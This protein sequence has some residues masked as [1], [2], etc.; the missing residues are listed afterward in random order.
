MSL[1]KN[2]I[3]FLEIG[4]VRTWE[5]MKKN[6]NINYLKLVFV[7]DKQLIFRIQRERVRKKLRS[8]FQSRQAMA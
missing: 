7:D 3:L 2:D 8:R 5:P 6:E 4:D 1:T